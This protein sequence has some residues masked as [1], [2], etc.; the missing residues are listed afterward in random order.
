[1]QAELQPDHVGDFVPRSESQ[2]K[3][4]E[5]VNKF[6]PVFGVSPRLALA[7]IR[8]E[9]NF[10]PT[11][12][13]PKNAQGLMQLIPE[14]SH[15]FNVKKPFDPEQNVRGG[16]AYLRW[17]LAY[18]QGNVALVAAAYNAGEG[19]V[20]RYRGIPPFPETRAYVKRIMEW[21][22]RAEHPFDETIT[23]PSP[24][25]GRIRPPAR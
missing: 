11:A 6:A 25:L 16:L 4:L 20:N 13:S 8:A 22:G 17:L 5:L 23:G 2:K 7:V 9:S 3:A 1:V 19:V 18:F 24:E 14:T 10:N 21:F 15:R 12:V